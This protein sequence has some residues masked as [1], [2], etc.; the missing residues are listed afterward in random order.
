MVIVRLLC[1]AGL[2]SVL[3]GSEYAFAQS[4]S[5]EQPDSIDL[6]PSTGRD[7]NQD[8]RIVEVRIEGNETVEIS[9]LPQLNTRAGQIFDPQAIEEDVR[10]LHRTRKFID[11]L[12][13]YVRVRQ[14]VVVVFT[15]V[16]R[17]TLRYVKFVGNERVTTR[18]LRKKAEI[19]VGD[20]IDSYVVEEARRRVESYYH[21]KGYDKA[22][23]TTVEGTKPGDRGA[24][25]LVD[26]G[27]SRKSFWT[28]FVGNTIATDARLLTQI[29]SKPGFF[30]FL[31]GDVDHEKI[32]ADVDTLTAYYRS[33][34]FFQARVGREV[35]VINGIGRD[36]ALLT[37]VI[38]EG[39]RYRVRNVSFL[40]NSRFKGEFLERD[41][42]LKSG[43]FFNQD[44]MDADLNLIRDIYGGRGFV[45]ADIQAD[46]DFLKSLVNSIWCTKLPRDSDI[47]L[48][49]LTYVLVVRIHILATASY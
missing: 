9:K 20:S 17:P 42:K 48:D 6:L 47:G 41:L 12:P 45:F 26:E 38:N 4:G 49:K 25:F 5:I 24:V 30:W 29:K 34:G 46:P 22:R 37:F 18:T 32:D 15:V 19:D 11:V 1:I 43:E 28:T 23:V 33:L 8:E 36:W 40:G 2:L 27:R 10:T 35:Q 14:G 21:E 16:E 44:H 31:G 3:T 13:K 39:P 7:T